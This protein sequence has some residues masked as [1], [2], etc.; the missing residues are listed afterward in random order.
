VTA[1]SAAR[2][3]AGSP[4]AGWILVVDDDEDIRETLVDVLADAGYAAR[5]AAGGREALELLAD[6]DL[7][8]L[9]LL[10][11]M[12]PGMDGFAFR[13]AQAADPRIASIPVLVV[14]A[15]RDLAKEARRL[16][17]TGWLQKPM[18]L[19]AVLR[20]VGSRCA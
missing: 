4:A 8:S 14:S 5:V 11:L 9:I 18:K 3:P 1:A 12:M 15:S 10:D 16:G 2:G 20:E 19:D 17:A 6:G 7:P 13:A